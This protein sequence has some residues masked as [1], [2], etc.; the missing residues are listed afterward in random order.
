MRRRICRLPESYEEGFSHDAVR[1]GIASAMI[2]LELFQGYCLERFERIRAELRRVRFDFAQ[3]DAARRYYLEQCEFL[4]ADN[5]RLVQLLRSELIERRLLESKIDELRFAATAAEDI[6][7]YA[8]ERC[9]QLQALSPGAD[10]HA[11]AD[12]QTRH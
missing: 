4:K 11:A 1:R 9:H 12:G 3:A 6:A 2:A 8:L 10:H 5:D 7:R